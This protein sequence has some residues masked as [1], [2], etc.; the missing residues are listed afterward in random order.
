MYGLEYFLFFGIPEGK[1]ELIDGRSRWVFPFLDRAAAE[2]HYQ[3]WLETLC[4]WK[5]L[6]PPEVTKSGSL[7]EAKFSEIEFELYPRPVRMTLPIAWEAFEAF[8][9]TCYRRD[10]WPGQPTGLATGW[11]SWLDN[12]D[13]RMK[14]WTLLDDL[15]ERFGGQ[16]GGRTDIAI[17]DT[18]GVCPPAYYY[19][20]GRENI[21]IEGDYFRSPPDLIAEVLMAAS[22]S[23]DRGERM[24]LYRRCGVPNLWLLEPEYE[25]VEVYELHAQYELVGTY[26]VGD[27]FSTPLFPGEQVAVER[28]FETQ[29]KR[30][31]SDVG[32]RPVKE[33]T[34]IPEWLLP[35]Q[36]K[37]GLEYFFLL[38]HPQHRWEF[39]NNKARSVLAFGSANEARARLA[40][41]AR[42]AGNW[43]GISN[44]KIS[45]LSADIDQTEIGRF[46]L[47]RQGRVVHCDVAVDGRRFQDLLGVWGKREAWDWGEE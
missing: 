47:L 13:I 36:M 28:L 21:M 18:A 40:N 41:F 42:E 31:R 22:R 14:L 35:P 6:S 23:L 4:R 30:R 34:P 43:E 2:A 9:S 11:D 45:P 24:E 46:Q 16:H 15:S 1:T 17:S 27:T 29:S 7:W 44:P 12:G 32:E 37:L 25:T 38:G 5:Q 3:L 20:A 26:G 8:H 10:F 19:R 33:P 39:W